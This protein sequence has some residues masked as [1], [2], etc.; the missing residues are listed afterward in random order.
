[1]E[2]G[3]PIVPSLV[4]GGRTVPILHVSQLA[5]A[6]GLP[7][8]PS[9]SPGRDGADAAAILE[10]WLGRLRTTP[11]PALLEPTPAR[12]RSLRNL[13]VNVF[14]PFE[15]LPGAWTSGEL[16]WRPEDDDT[17]EAALA[18]PDDLIAFAE[19]A[20]AGWRSF[21]DAHELAGRDPP[22]ATPR[23][24][25]SFSTLVA[26]Q[27]WHAAYHYRQLVSV[28]GGPDEVLDLPAFDD[29][30]LPSDVF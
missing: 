23:G 2:A 22:V 25:V 9:D 24:R 17:R 8:P 26:F 28:L 11:W 20:A 5:E 6:L 7:S 29:L 1:M 27:R 18:T 21:L 15:L 14:H 16:D 3:R 12:G 10:A 30:A 19:S 13:T 4:V